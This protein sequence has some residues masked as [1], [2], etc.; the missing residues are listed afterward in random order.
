MDFK[1][2]KVCNLGC[3]ASSTCKVYNVASSIK[4]DMNWETHEM[5]SNA[6]TQSVLEGEKKLKQIIYNKCELEI[7]LLQQYPESFLHCL[8]CYTM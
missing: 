2:L 6:T 5:D 8:L 4:G 1:T 7:I 3:K